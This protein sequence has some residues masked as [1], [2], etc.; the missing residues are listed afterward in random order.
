MKTKIGSSE[1]VS[2]SLLTGASLLI[3][4]WLYI[5]SRLFSEANPFGDISLYNFWWFQVESGAPIYGFQADWIYPALAFV[6]I[7]VAGIIDLVSYEISWLLMV[8]LLNTAAALVLYRP[9][10]K[11]KTPTLAGWFYLLGLLALGPVAVS[12]IDSVSLALAVFAVVLVRRRAITSAAILFTIAGWIKIWPIALF[13]AMIAAFKQSA[14]ALIAAL[15]ISIS[16]FSIG[17]YAGGQAVL[18]FISG[19][20]D[21]GIQ[22]ESVLATPWMWL[23]KFELASIYFD[24]R[25]ITNQVAGPLVDEVAL[26]SNIAMFL[27]LGVIFFVTFLEKKRGRDSR[28]LFFL[29]SFA[30]VLSLIVFN[31]VGS[32]QFIL[33]LIAPIAA[34]IIF[35]IAKIKLLVFLTLAVLLLSQL[36]YPIFYIPL[37]ALEGYALWLLTLRNLLLVVLLV[38]VFLR[39]TRQKSLQ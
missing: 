10:K 34:G 11:A 26:F 13:S 20:Q 9:T 21:R 35:R 2:K 5:A 31:K 37:L 25:V 38:M 16:I 27:V 7:W 15:T 30:G 33:W 12:R 23:A 19:Q 14:K 17:F 29:A 4:L 36:V 18:S 8:F 28:I 6:P 1:L 32:P 39:L 3:H 22:I 24:D